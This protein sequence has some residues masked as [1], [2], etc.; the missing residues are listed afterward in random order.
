LKSWRQ[1][2]RCGRALVEIC[3]QQK[4]Q[5]I[6]RV[7]NWGETAHAA[8]H[9]KSMNHA[10]HEQSVET[11]QGG[12][13]RRLLLASS[14]PASALAALPAAASTPMP[15]LSSVPVLVIALVLGILA[16]RLAQDFLVPL[17][18]GLLIAY[19]LDPIVRTMHRLGVPRW[20]GA[21]A[22]V[23]GLVLA[24][25]GVV[26]ALGDRVTT[27]INQLPEATGRLREELRSIGGQAGALSAIGKAADDLEAAASEAAGLQAAAASSKAPLG[28]RLRESLVLR[29]MTLLGVTSTMFMLVL[30]VYFL[31]A[32]G[33]LFK[34]KIVW[35]AGPAPSSRGEVAS[36]IDDINR[37]IEHF[38]SVVIA[39]NVLVGL[40][41]WV[42]FHALGLANAWAWAIMAGLLNTVPFLGSAVAALVFFL[43][44]LLQF[45][46]VGAALVTAGVFIVI[47]SFESMLVTP[48]LLGRAI[49]MN[50]VAV[51]GGLLF[52][53][54]LWGPWG[55]ALSFPMMA[56]I[57]TI[58]DRVG[59]LRPVG[60]M[61]G[62]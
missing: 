15:R 62:R 22:I 13:I 19:A 55:L 52:W 46:A 60:E 28:L 4:R 6:A 34:R 61:L 1:Q 49:R 59:S 18:L 14:Q 17:V 27:A 21:A 33:D 54:W 7:T 41:T 56:A 3:V 58:A 5:R 23:A 2:H 44:A 45:D 35:L 42:A 53:G 12:T 29:S 43:A 47:T 20:L 36:T 40:C 10:R 8:G 50:N 32:A 9:A 38:L 11:A 30:F 24:L 26:Y 39:M 25:G 51:F 16:L 37:N 57:K 48:W 31:L